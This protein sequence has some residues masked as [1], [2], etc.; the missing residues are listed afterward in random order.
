MK[1]SLLVFSYEK[2][3]AP[4][5]TLMFHVLLFAKELKEKGEDVKILF[6]GEGV[7]WAKELINPEHPFK[8]HVEYLKDNF[9]ACEACS[10]MHGILDDIVGKVAIENDLHGHISLKKYLDD[11]GKV[12]EF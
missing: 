9:V 7:Q 10:S 11:D 12:V 3:G 2:D 5:N 4:M 1:I 8:K 6:E